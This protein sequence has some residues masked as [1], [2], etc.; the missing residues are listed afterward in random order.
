M[1][2]A[3]MVLGHGEDASILQKTIDLL[4]CDN[5][6]FFIHW[7]RKY[8]QPFLYSNISKIYMIKK[9]ILVS[10][11]TDSQVLAE[12][13]LF[14]SVIDKG[15]YD[16][17]HLIS[18]VDMPLMTKDYF[19]DY[20]DKDA[21]LGFSDVNKSIYHRI[22]WYYPF[23][24][25]NPRSKVGRIYKKILEISNLIFQVNRIKDQNI[26]KGCNWF[27]IKI[28]L[29]NEVVNFDNFKMFLS[30]FCAD[31]VY[32]QTILQRYKPKKLLEDDNTMAARYI[33][34]KRGNPYVFT[35]KDVTELR[36]VIN[37]R[38]AF[39]RKIESSKVIEE[40]YK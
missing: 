40:V 21:Y 8:K 23:G 27:S 10:W 25:I 38:Y 34:W 24:K 9:P 28:D 26:E 5:I 18:S 14:Q 39:A 30:S 31:E 12:K 22:S 13:K 35:L 36:S 2:H 6:D 4:D 1:K 3:I 7:D 16:Y 33:D 19:L 20:F 11:G 37:T 29:L 17:V 15:G 32:V